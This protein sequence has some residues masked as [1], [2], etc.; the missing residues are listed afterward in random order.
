M[1]AAGRRKPG[2]GS[3]RATVGTTRRF[4]LKSRTPCPILWLPN[5][6]IH[7]P[8]I[9]SRK[10]ENQKSKIKNPMIIDPM[11]CGK[12][13][14]MDSIEDAAKLNVQHRTTFYVSAYLFQCWI[15][16]LTLDNVAQ[17]A[18]KSDPNQRSFQTGEAWR[19]FLHFFG[20]AS[21]AEFAAIFGHLMQFGDYDDFMAAH[22]LDAA[23]A[24]SIEH[25]ITGEFLG[26]HTSRQ[27]SSEPQKLIA[28]I[29]FTTTRLCDWLDALLHFH[30]LQEW[31]VMPD[32]FDPDPQKRELSYLAINKQNFDHLSERAQVHWL[33]HMADTAL[34]LKKSPKWDVYHQLAA[35]PTPKPRPWP[36]E[37][38]DHVIIKLWPVLKSYHWSP[39]NLLF[40]LRKIL[41]S[42][43]L[44]PC[45]DE[46]AVIAYC[47]NT[48]SL[49]WPSPGETASSPASHRAQIRNRKA[50]VPS[51]A[52]ENQNSN[53]EN[54]LSSIASAK[55]EESFSLAL[56]LCQD[57]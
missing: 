10:I 42:A 27:L 53:I 22:V 3:E 29:R 44:G 13:P 41:K 36:T 56:R 8:I 23:A 33:T 14:L 39:A 2:A 49:R 43:D 51:T 9:P 45:A 5:P 11:P 52:S 34:E 30:A 15:C 46:S 31:H 25:E 6:P 16:K 54:H 26:S 32:C 57:L 35:A 47:A 17:L 18:E 1:T 4:C 21:D 50:G 19:G 55:E 37:R 28:L 24:L 12:L 40:V 20:K 38:L 7:Y 48:L